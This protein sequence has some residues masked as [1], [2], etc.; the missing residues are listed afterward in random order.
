MPKNINYWLTMKTLIKKTLFKIRNKIKHYH[1]LSK[2]WIAHTHCRWR[3]KRQFKILD[4]YISRYRSNGGLKNPF[5]HYKLFSLVQILQEE[6]PQAILELGT[7]LSTIFFS[8]Y[9]RENRDVSLTCVDES[10]YWLENSRK[11]AEIDESDDRFCMIA[12][13]KLF[14]HHSKLKQIKYDVDLENKFDCVFIDGPSS[15]VDGI[16]HKDAV[17]TN[18]FDVAERALPRLIIVDIRRATVEEIRK[19]YGEKYDV[20][21]SD[22][23][24]GTIRNNYRY[25]SIFKLK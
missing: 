12:A 9:V 24:T 5:Q 7:G 14:I 8:K 1:V 11:L 23:L 18:I 3:N 21:I 16:K 20:E 19:R 2:T 4:G 6:K 13:K 22:V 25:F 17:N 10:R 15:E